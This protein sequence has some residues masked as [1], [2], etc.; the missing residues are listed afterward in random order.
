MTAFL[1]A[2]GEPAVRAIVDRFVDRMANDFVIGL[3]WS[4][5]RALEL[6]RLTLRGNVERI[7]GM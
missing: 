7:F 5:E 4:E 3:G 6:G 2:G 1:R